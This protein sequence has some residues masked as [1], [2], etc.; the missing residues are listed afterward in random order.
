MYIIE[1]IN[2]KQVMTVEVMSRWQRVIFVNY[3]TVKT[4]SL[5]AVLGTDA[6]TVRAEAAAMGLEP[7]VYD[8]N[9]L[10]RG[11]VTILRNNWA[12]LSLEDICTLLE[13]PP[14]KLDVLLAEYDFLGEKLGP[15][16]AAERVRYAPL[17]VQQRENTARIRSFVQEHYQSPRVAPFDFYSTL[18]AC[19]EFDYGQ[20]IPRFYASYCASYSGTLLDDSLSDYSHE[21]L[22]RLRAA[23]TNGIWLHESLRNLAPFPL[24][25]EYSGEYELRVK[26]LDALT[27]RCADYGIDVYLYLNEPRSLPASFFENHPELRGQETDEGEYCLCT[28]TAQVQQY[29]YD[30]VKYLAGHVPLLKG[31]MTITMSE[32]PTHCHSKKWA[33]GTK[34]CPRCRHRSPQQTAAE[35]NNL[36]AKALA[37][38]NGYTRL[39]ANLW[40]WSAFM[41]WTHEQTLEGVRLLDPAVD[42]LCVSEYSKDFVRGGVAAQVVD[43]SISV[44]GPSRGSEEILRYA[45]RLGHRVW[46]K[47]QVNNSWECSAVPYLPVFD[48]MTRHIRNLKDMGVEG[49]MMGWSLGGY[50]GGA[51]SLCNLVCS[52]EDFDEKLWYDAVYEASAPAVREAVGSFSR[53]FE[54]FPFSVDGLYYGGQTLGPG[55][56]ILDVSGRSSSMVCFTFADYERYTQPYGLEIYLEQYRKLLERW[57]QGLALLEGVQGNAALISLQNAAL[58]AYIHFAAAY[59]V[60]LSARCRRT[61]DSQG[62]KDCAG[63]MLELTKRLYGLICRDAA[64]GFE[65]TNHY[66]YNGNLLLLRMLELSRAVE[67]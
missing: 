53:A 51:M 48:L 49:F 62:L 3:G 27:R 57:E 4:Q 43:Y 17:T 41:G 7:I 1:K 22:Q 9:W 10:R 65:M 58:G 52:R 26:N 13:L 12:L 54:E 66:Y 15:K 19:P 33:A 60:A 18:P 2:W 23:G 38:G 37:D 6:D 50:P 67:G 8:P 25:P 32:N 64:I 24:A 21:A 20:D 55:N 5:A 44:V 29:I 61:G 14:Q 47:V 42:V 30:A 11:F 56:D 39:I 40:G 36:M 28:G 35:L 16:P 45:R 34:P 46:A 63:Q 59:R 31:V